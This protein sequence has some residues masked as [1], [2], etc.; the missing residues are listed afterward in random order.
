M[1]NAKK[2]FS[3]KILNFVEGLP[4]FRKGALSRLQDIRTRQRERATKS[5][6]ERK[7]PNQIDIRLDQI[8]LAITFEHEDFRLIQK[9]LKKFFPKNTTIIKFLRDFKN[10]KT[11]YMH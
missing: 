4:R 2:I 1:K 6:L 7:I 5:Y 10:E 11:A 8:T 3:E 9:G